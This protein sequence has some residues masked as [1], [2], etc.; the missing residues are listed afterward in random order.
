LQELLLGNNLLGNKAAKAF[1]L[2]FTGGITKLKILDISKNEITDEGGVPL[3][4]AL[5]E[6]DST[7][8]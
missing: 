1:A 7:N 4:Q 5:L 6:K 8:L 2:A 3:A